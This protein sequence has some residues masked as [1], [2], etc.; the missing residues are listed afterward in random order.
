MLT[1][2]HPWVLATPLLRVPVYHKRTALVNL[3]M[4]KR[5]TCIKYFGRAAAGEGPSGRQIKG[6]GI[7][8]RPVC[9][10]PFWEEKGDPVAGEE[11]KTAALLVRHERSN[12]KTGKLS[13]GSY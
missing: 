13:R 11:D 2:P 1:G 5:K 9:T 7:E 6:R 12:G 3:I 4:E 8:M 10:L